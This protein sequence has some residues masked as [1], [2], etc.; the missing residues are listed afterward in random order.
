MADYNELSGD[1]GIPLSVGIPGKDGATFTPTVSEDG[2]LSWENNRGLPNPAPVNVAAMLVTLDGATK[3]ASHSASEITS[4]IHNSKAVHAYY[5]ASNNRLELTL[6]AINSDTVTFSSYG[7]N[8]ETRYRIAEDKTFT[9][10]IETFNGGGSADSPETSSSYVKYSAQTP[11]DA[12]KAQARKNIGAISEEDAKALI[13]EVGGYYTP[14]VTQPDENTLQFDFTPSQ[15]G[16]PEVDPV[17]VSL[18]EDVN[19]SSADITSIKTILGNLMTIIKAQ[20]DSEGGVERPQGYNMDISGLVTQNDTLIAALG[21]V[22]D[23]SDDSGDDSGGTGEDTHTHSYTSEV[24]TAATCETAGVRTYT[25]EC[26]ETYT[27][28]IPAIGHNYVDGI[29][30]VCGAADPDYDA[31]GDTNALTMTRNDTNQSSSVWY[32]ESGA[33]FDCVKNG[34]FYKSGAVADADC[35]V[36]IGFTAGSNNSGIVY[37]VGQIKREDRLA[38][39]YAEQLGTASTTEQLKTYTVHQGY[40]LVIAVANSSEPTLDVTY[41]E[42]SFT[43][44]SE[45]YTNMVEGYTLNAYLKGSTGV[46]TADWSQQNVSDLIDISAVTEIHILHI[47]SDGFTMKHY[48]L[49][50]SFYDSAETFVSGGDVPSEADEVTALAV[51]DGAKYVRVGSNKN[52][53]KYGVYVGPNSEPY[54]GEFVA[55]A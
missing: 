44:V 4:R 30:S 28:S 54:Y 45:F 32:D 40:E 35:E 41:E 26:G 48:A 51:P 29:C 3:T 7:A 2:T 16:M 12:Q 9:V 37:Y 27:E 43:P 17:Q 24:T 31:G 47:A 42:G 19:V 33:E 13:P 53:T 52:N 50:Y 6:S 22:D 21:T 14:V 11:T 39:Y 18:P 1:L 46:I 38:V 20:T 34:Y 55:F 15:E 36:T 25:C 10:V 49:S 8:T 23:S 5:V